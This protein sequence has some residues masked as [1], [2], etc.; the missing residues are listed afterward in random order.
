[1][2]GDEIEN[3][4]GLHLGSFRACAETGDVPHREDGLVALQLR[5]SL[6]LHQSLSDVAWAQVKTFCVVIL[7]QFSGYTPY[8]FQKNPM[9]FEDL[10][11]DAREDPM[12]F[13]TYRPAVIGYVTEAFTPEWCT[14]VYRADRDGMVELFRCSWDS[15][16]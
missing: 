4:S 13:G 10:E 15:S 8:Y 16:G 5:E 7:D 6:L 3:S 14:T 2:V 9:R 1:M 11:A 12:F